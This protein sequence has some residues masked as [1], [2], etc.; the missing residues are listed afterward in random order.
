MRVALHAIFKEY[1]LHV[2]IPMLSSQMVFVPANQDSFKVRILLA[3]LAPETA[4][5][6]PV[7]IFVRLVWIT[8]ILSTGSADALTDSRKL[9]KKLCY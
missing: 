6:V 8:P 7:R 3:N 4:G 2:R 5:S 1:A 9:S